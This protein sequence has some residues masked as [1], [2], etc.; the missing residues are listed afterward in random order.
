MGRLL[1]TCIIGACLGL[2][3]APADEKLPLM[4][5]I[6]SGAIST[7]ILGKWL[8]ELGYEPKV[9]STQVFQVEIVRDRWPVYI[10]LSLSNDGSRIWLESKFSPIAEPDRVPPKAWKQLLEINDV[11]GPAHF[12]FDSTDRR[13]HLYCPV[14]NHSL[15]QELVRK[16]L[17]RFDNT[18]RQTQQYWRGENFLP[19]G[20]SVVKVP[21]KNDA[22]LPLLKPEEIPNKAVPALPVGLDKSSDA[23]RFSEKW[24]I[25]EIW[26]KGTKTPDNVLQKNK[27][28]VRF[29]HDGTGIYA[30]LKSIDNERTVKVKID[31]KPKLREIDFISPLNGEEL[32]VYQLDEKKLTICFAAPGQPRPT[33]MAIQDKETWIA[34]VLNQP[35]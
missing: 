14:K 4:R 31:H 19:E 25:Q 12:S 5:P 13:I 35:K 1:V 21:P 28:E 7:D 20:T 22:P 24:Q 23:V 18:V 26:I 9:L 15:T 16:E 3:S 11:I 8:R 10:L 27:P 33:R 17:D 2:G 34:F 6:P 29:F 30:Q 32:G